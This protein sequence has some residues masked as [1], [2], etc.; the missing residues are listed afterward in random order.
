VKYLNGL[1][2]PRAIP[3]KQFS[4]EVSSLVN[5]VIARL[6]E[7]NLQDCE[8]AQLWK[9]ILEDQ[10]DPKELRYRMIEAELGFHPE[11]GSKSL[12]E[13]ALA[14]KQKIGEASFSELTGAYPGNNG[15]GLDSMIALVESEGIVGRPQIPRLDIQGIEREPWKPAVDAARELRRKIGKPDGVV[16]ND[17]LY[18]LLSLTKQDVE[19]W[20][21]SGK[22]TA[23]VVGNVNQDDMKF[24][25]RKKHPIA[26]RFE[27]ARI[28]GDC[29][30]SKQHDRESWLVSTD[31]S[32]TR[33]KYQRAFA[34]ELL[35]PILSLNEYLDGDYSESA[36]EDAAD[37]FSVSEKTIENSLVN[38]GYISRDH[39]ETNMPYDLRGD[40]RY[41][42]ADL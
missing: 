41:S 24:V 36:V 12:I 42:R 10:G 29:T 22:A 32:T 9:L 3:R 20:V 33:Q 23:S 1:N 6:H 2:R 7:T 25:L 38:N 15:N 37:H 17:I 40:I 21:P 30:V 4:D 14:L 19:K 13:K 39:L 8:L 16:S 35:S 28:I 11:E 31:S 18:D 26:K 34:T 5:H 27:L